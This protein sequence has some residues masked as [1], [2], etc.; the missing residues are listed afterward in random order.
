MSF[1]ISENE[2][3]EEEIKPEN[4]M[5][6]KVRYLMPKSEFSS[7]DADLTYINGSFFQLGKKNVGFLSNIKIQYSDVSLGDKKSDL[8]QIIYDVGN[9]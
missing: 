8:S 2:I 4:K 5:T 1:E 3:D 6:L 7:K 9:N